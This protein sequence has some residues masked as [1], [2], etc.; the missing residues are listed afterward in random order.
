MEELRA[1]S[2]APAPSTEPPPS[3]SPPARDLFSTWK[4]M[5]RRNIAFE[6]LSD[7]TAFRV[8]MPSR[9]SFYAALGTNSRRLPRHLRP[10]RGLHAH[11]ESQWLPEHAHRSASPRSA[12]PEDRGARPHRQHARDRQS[13]TRCPLAFLLGPVAIQSL[14]NELCSSAPSLLV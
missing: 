6:R 4:K 8:V 5:Q 1:N 2:S 13:R 12:Q 3:A 9:K 10:L 7:I 14:G 11:P